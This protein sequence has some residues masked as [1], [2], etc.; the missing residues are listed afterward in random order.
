MSTGGKALPADRSN[1]FRYREGAQCIYIV[2]CGISER[3]DGGRYH[4]SAV[5]QR[6]FRNIYKLRLVL[7]IE[8]CTVGTVIRVLAV[9]Q[10]GC[11]GSTVVEERRA[12]AGDGLREGH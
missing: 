1:G 5:C 3:S 9:N 7:V 4:I 12:D 10:Y 11:K 2:E 8:G 6:L